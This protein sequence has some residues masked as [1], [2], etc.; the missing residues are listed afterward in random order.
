VPGPI[1]GDGD[2]LAF[3]EIDSAVF[4]AGLDGGKAAI[5]IEELQDLL[6]RQ[7]PLEAVVEQMI[8]R[9]PPLAKCRPAFANGRTRAV[10]MLQ[11]LLIARGRDTPLNAADYGWATD[12]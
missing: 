9:V 10:R 6:S 11:T 7:V 4:E 1:Y 8:A 12:S 5:L 3:A 2:W